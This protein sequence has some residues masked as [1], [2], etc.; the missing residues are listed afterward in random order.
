MKHLKPAMFFAYLKEHDEHV[1]HTLVGHN[2]YV[3]QKNMTNVCPIPDFTA[4]VTVKFL[5][6]L[7]NLADL[8]ISLGF[9]FL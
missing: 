7:L 4:T 9:F 5:R 3:P 8:L 6:R 2:V 1:Y